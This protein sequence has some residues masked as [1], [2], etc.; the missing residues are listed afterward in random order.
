M[1]MNT[2]KMMIGAALAAGLGMSTHSNAATLFTLSD[3]TDATFEHDS[4]GT[5]SPS[6]IPS[7]GS[8]SVGNGTFEWGALASDTTQNT[9]IF[10]GGTFTSSDWGGLGRFTSDAIDVSSIDTVDI[11]GQFDGLFNTDTEFSNFFYALDGGTAVTF[12]AGVEDT[13]AT[14]QAVGVSGLDVSSASSMVVGFEFDHNGSSDF[15]NVD[16]LTVVP[17]PASL[18]LLGLGGLMMLGRRRSA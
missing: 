17:E 15:F 11:A 13:E 9:A 10:S 4:D 12:G 1:T 3:T 5:N 2:K 6:P 14:D 7:A 8:Q 16:S 18:A